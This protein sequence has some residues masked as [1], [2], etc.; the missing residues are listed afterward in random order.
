[1][2]NK[3]E[4]VIVILAA[5][6]LLYGAYSLLFGSKAKKPGEHA[7]RTAAT[8]S[9]QW[10]ESIQDS[11]KQTRITPLQGLVVQRALE[12]WPDQL[13]LTAALPS[14]LIAEEKRKQAEAQRAA[15]LA[16]EEA[17][18]ARQAKQDEAERLRQAKLRLAKRFVYSGY[19]VLDDPVP[20]TPCAV[21][22]GIVYR[23]GETLE[24]SS[25]V[26]KSIT[27]EEVVIV[28]PEQAIEVHIPITK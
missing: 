25:H 9:I 19:A 27:P 22:N 10:V 28:S 20:R 3:R 21:L 8:S 1:M 26:V 2:H 5:V 7:R 13:I 4:K 24:G 15:R 14:E 11:L 16:T 17:E 23:A 6:S 12:P 18:R